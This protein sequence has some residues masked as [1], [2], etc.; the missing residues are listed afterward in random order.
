MHLDLGWDHLIWA[1]EQAMTEGSLKQNSCIN[2]WLL[3]LA[4]GAL[5]SQIHSKV[6]NLCESKH[7]DTVFPF[8]PLQVSV[9]SWP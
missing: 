8:S 6:P 3:S 5:D 9:V 2:I 4:S 1:R 7:M